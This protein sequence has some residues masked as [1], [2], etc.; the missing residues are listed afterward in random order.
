MTGI[1]GY[2]PRE[3]ENVSYH[4]ELVKLAENLA[5]KSATAKNIVTALDA[6]LDAEVL[7]LLSVPAQLKEMLLQ[8]ARL[9]VYTP[10]NEHFGIVP[11]EAML[12]GVPVLATNSGGPRET[13]VEAQ[14]GWLRDPL[15]VDEW[16]EVMRKVLGE[17]SDSDIVRMGR[18]GKTRVR[19]EFSL[20]QLAKRL[21]EELEDM[22][23]MSRVRTWELQDVLLAIGV[24]G[25]VVVALV[26]MLSSILTVK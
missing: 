19:A 18:Q 11:L 25:V 20:E 23:N 2:D 24:S 7:F 3:A 1:G 5:L 22:V 6:P 13:V 17:M 16:A 4:E 12:A 26:A 14:T 10:T 15:K 21:D 9:L 8:T